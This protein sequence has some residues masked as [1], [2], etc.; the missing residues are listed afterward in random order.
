MGEVFIAKRGQAL[1]TAKGK[2]GSGAFYISERANPPSLKLPP[3]LKLRRTARRA[4]KN[5][6]QKQND[7]RT[8]SLLI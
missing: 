2:K 8:P 3:T 6:E 5:T 7:D 4:G 1:F